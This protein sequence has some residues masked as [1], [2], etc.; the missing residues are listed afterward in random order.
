MSKSNIL[1]YLSLLSVVLS[2][3]LWV[4]VVSFSAPEN[5]SLTA[6]FVGLWAPTLMSMSNRYKA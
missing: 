6:I 4:G 5:A 2:I 1:F 3:A